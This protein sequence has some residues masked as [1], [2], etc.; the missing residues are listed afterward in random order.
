M[1]HVSL[2][3]KMN[4]IAK[5]N[6]FVTALIRAGEVAQSL[7]IKHSMGD[8]NIN[9]NMNECVVELSQSYGD[10]IK[11]EYVITIWNLANSD[12]NEVASLIFQRWGLA[13]LTTR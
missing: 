1:K 8:V 3:R 5:N 10:G 9:V 6:Q 4:T 13:C 12:P 11:L 7:A 2:K